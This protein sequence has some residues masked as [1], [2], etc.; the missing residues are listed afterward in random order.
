MSILVFFRYW[1]VKIASARSVLAPFVETWFLFRSFPRLSAGKRVSAWTCLKGLGKGFWRVRLP[2]G[3]TR[4]G[5]SVCCRPSESLKPA[6]RSYFP[7]WQRL[8][9]ADESSV[10]SYFLN[11]DVILRGNLVA[12]QV[13]SF[14]EPFVEILQ[15][16][17]NNYSMTLNLSYIPCEV[18]LRFTVLMKLCRTIWV[19][20]DLL[21]FSFICV[22][23]NYNLT[24]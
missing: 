4:L 14:L 3:E 16:F 23:F 11:E 20:A 13:D 7:P 17:L 22:F 5:T 12:N 6:L 9:I 1:N 2:G 15:P 19:K 21:I 8:K 18:I 10:I 24:I